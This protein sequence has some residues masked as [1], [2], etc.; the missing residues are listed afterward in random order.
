M[1][2]DDLQDLDEGGDEEEDDD[3]DDVSDDAEMTRVTFLRRQNELLK[4]RLDASEKK[5][6]DLTKKI[7]ELE[8]SLLQGMLQCLVFIRTVGQV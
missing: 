2:D 5:V 1:F 3:A 6:E 7:Q 8:R 4:E